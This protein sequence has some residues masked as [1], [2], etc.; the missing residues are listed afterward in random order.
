MK[1][2]G[3]LDA[4]LAQGAVCSLHQ[5]P[6][7]A[8]AAEFEDHPAAGFERAGHRGGSRFG[9]LDPMQY[10]IRKD[11]VEFGFIR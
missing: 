3:L 8:V 10:G 6:D 4:Q 7:I 9:R 2:S 5:D 11:S 1:R